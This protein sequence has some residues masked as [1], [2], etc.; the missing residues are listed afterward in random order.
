VQEKFPPSASG[1]FR[2]T[3]AEVRIDVVR[4]AI[5]SYYSEIYK[6]SS[7]LCE[8]HGEEK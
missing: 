1:Y 5:L 6:L 3:D 4:T 8:Q 7:L 2:V